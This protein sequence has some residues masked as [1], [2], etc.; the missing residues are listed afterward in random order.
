M[1]GGQIR[2]VLDQGLSDDQLAHH[3]DEIVEL[4]GVH[5]D[6]ARSGGCFLSERKRRAVGRPDELARLALEGVAVEAV[7]RT[8]REAVLGRTASDERSRAGLSGAVRDA[9]SSRLPLIAPLVM[10]TMRATS[11]AASE[12]GSAP[13]ST[14]NKQWAM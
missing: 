1:N 5:F 3:L 8:A 13:V 4:A 14:A 9:H 6:G 10:E 2:I 7:A 11:G 12:A